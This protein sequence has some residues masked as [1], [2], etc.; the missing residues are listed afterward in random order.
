M[1]KRI[2]ELE[3]QLANLEAKSKEYEA[4]WLK[5]QKARLAQAN[6]LDLWGAVK[7]KHKFDGMQIELDKAKAESAM[8]DHELKNEVAGYA[9][10]LLEFSEVNQQLTKLKAENSRLQFAADCWWKHRAHYPYSPE[11][12][13]VETEVRQTSK[14]G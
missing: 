5:E 11:L 7:A 1:H 9:N 4:N 8:L 3:K 12:R 14:N 13:D 6:F 10:L 2:V